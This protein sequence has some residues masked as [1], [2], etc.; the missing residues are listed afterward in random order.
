MSRPPHTSELC[1]WAIDEELAGDYYKAAGKQF[2]SHK[3]VNHSFAE[4]A[5]GHGIHV[6]TL[7]GYFP[8]SSAA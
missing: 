5:R 7:E 8:S 6:N 1:D 4:Y 2:A 3:S